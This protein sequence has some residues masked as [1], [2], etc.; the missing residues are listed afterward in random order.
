MKK[1]TSMLMVLLLITL[2][3]PGPVASACTNLIITKGASKTG[4]VTIC[5]TCDAS[6][7]SHLAFLPGGDHE[8]GTFVTYPEM[9]ARGVQVKQVPHTYAV[10]ASNG[11]GHMNEHQ[12]AIGETTFGGR[13][14]LNDPQGL[15]YADLITLALQRCKTARQAIKCIADLAAEYGYTQSGESFSIGDT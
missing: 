11:I 4:S 9:R 7:P 10:L 8:P 12:L 6:F 5:Y 3:T 2:L 13:R 1:R 15:H 14:G